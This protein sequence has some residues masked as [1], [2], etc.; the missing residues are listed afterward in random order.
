MERQSPRTAP[1]VSSRYPFQSSTGQRDMA[2]KQ[3]GLARQC[4]ER[5]S[6]RALGVDEEEGEIPNPDS[7]GKPILCG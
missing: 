2:G 3:E 6:R 5:G 4:Q 1:S 7:G